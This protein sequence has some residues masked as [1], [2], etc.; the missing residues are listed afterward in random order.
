LVFFGREGRITHVGMQFAENTFI[1]ASGG[2]GVV[3][4]EWGD[5]HYTPTYVDA[6]R[7]DATCVGQAIER[8]ESE[9]R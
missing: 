8:Y 6:R 4:T 5:R 9:T 3:V 1:H 2:A 7:F